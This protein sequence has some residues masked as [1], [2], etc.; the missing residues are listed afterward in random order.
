VQGRVSF[1]EFHVLRLSLLPVIVIGACIGGGGGGGDDDEDSGSDSGAPPLDS[2]DDS[3]DGSGGGDDCEPEP[4]QCIDQA[5]L[6]LSLHDDMV[7]MG[8]VETETDGA[9]FVTEVDASAGGFGNETQ[10]PWVYV[11]FTADGA[12]RVDI[13]DETAMEESMDWDLAARRFILRLNGG[14][15]GP[16]CVG[17]AVMNGFSYDEI[18]SVPDGASYVQDEY[19]TGDCTMIN[20]SS[21]IPGS[22]QVALGPWWSYSSCVETTG[23]PFVLELADGTHIKFVVEA[24]YRGTGQEECNTDGSTNKESARYTFRWAWL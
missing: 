1:S 20:D 10:E 16:S 12:V 17:A 2:G 22:P 24:Y 18:A 8:A 19:Y 13:D 15:S 4:P 21:G 5:I 14:D 23:T 11:K 9:D 3:G 6:D 7:S